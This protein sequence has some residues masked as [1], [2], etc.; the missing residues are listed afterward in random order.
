[1]SQWVTDKHCQWSNSGPIKTG[2]LAKSAQGARLHPLVLLWVERVYKLFVS[3]YFLF[4]IHCRAILKNIGKITTDSWAECFS[5]KLKYEKLSPTCR[6][7][8]P[9]HYHQQQQ[10][11]LSCH[12]WHQSNHQVI[13]WRGKAMI[14]SRSDN[15]YKQSFSSVSSPL[16][17]MSWGHTLRPNILIS[18]CSLMMTSGGAWTS[19]NCTGT[20]P[21]QRLLHNLNMQSL[22]LHL[23]PQSIFVKHTVDRR[24]AQCLLWPAYASIRNWCKEKY[25]ERW[26]MT[27]GP[28]SSFFLAHLLASMQWHRC[29][30]HVCRNVV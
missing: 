17:L 9:Q 22:H 24:C 8:F 6:Q 30:A 20:V 19:S 28:A 21:R 5:N 26:S 13:L 29:R 14:G 2:T 4:C 27:A 18:I 11:V 12:N 3:F 16:P 23:C 15:Q 25:Q 10:Q 7:G 1:M